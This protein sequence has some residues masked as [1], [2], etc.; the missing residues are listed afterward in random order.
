MSIN[1]LGSLTFY[2]KTVVVDQLSS[3]KKTKENKFVS[4]ISIQNT[5]NEHFIHITL[6]I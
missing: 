5:N 4:A 3:K 1:L 6:S 2:S